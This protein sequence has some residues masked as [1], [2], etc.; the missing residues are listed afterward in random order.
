[1]DGRSEQDTDAQPASDL[2]ERLAR[3]QVD[4]GAMIRSLVGGSP[5][6][7]LRQPGLPDHGG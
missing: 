1:M 6:E 7:P 4:V 5:E 3:I 2:T